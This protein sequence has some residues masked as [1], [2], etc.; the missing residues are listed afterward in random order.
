MLI[1][2]EEPEM[3]DLGTS[4]RHCLATENYYGALFLTLV[5]PSVCGA[6]ES[7]D[8]KDSKT[9]YATW[10]DRYVFNLQL[11]G[12]DCYK[13]RCTVLHQATTLQRNAPFRRVI[14]TFPTQGGNV[15]HNNVLN[16]AL[17]LDIPRFCDEVLSGVDRWLLATRGDQSVTQNEETMLKVYPNGLAP[18]MV[19]HPVIS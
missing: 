5:V 3:N 19:G 4:I 16:D 10:F 7:A 1:A 14:F 6:L 15:F 9:K 13:L 17:N 11:T 8:G 2:F 12:E 18:F